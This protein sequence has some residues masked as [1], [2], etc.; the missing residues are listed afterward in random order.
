MSSE[1]EMKIQNGLD[2]QSRDVE[3]S[4]VESIIML[5][6]RKLFMLAECYLNL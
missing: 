1:K 2:L 4:E 5:T 3:D 6:S